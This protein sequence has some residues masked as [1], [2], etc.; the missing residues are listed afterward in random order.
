MKDDLLQC[1]ASIP[2]FITR[3]DEALETVH[4]NEAESLSMRCEE[5]L[6]L[7][8]VLMG[9]VEDLGRTLVLH[10]EIVD[11]QQLLADITSIVSSMCEYA[12]H[13]LERTMA[14]QDEVFRF[15]SS[16][17]VVCPIIRNGPGRPAYWISPAQI[18]SLIEVG[19]TH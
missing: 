14:L 16:A 15:E 19:Y 10:I 12:E 2:S 8:R 7:L 9:R 3:L 13:F 5:Y 17:T 11:C 4:L 18:E 6:Q 1:I